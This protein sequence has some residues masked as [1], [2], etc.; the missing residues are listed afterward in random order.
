M[1]RATEPPKVGQLPEYLSREMRRLESELQDG[2]WVYPTLAGSF[3]SYGGA[4]AQARFCRNH[5]GLVV[6]GGL[7]RDGATGTNSYAVVMTLPEKYRPS[8]QLV[9]ATTQGGATSG[10][11]M[12]LDVRTNGEVAA[13]LWNQTWLSLDGISFYAGR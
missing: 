4:Y 8:H 7:V 9:F 1:F 12:R 3:Q 2:G 13:Y 11:F 6:L 5:H 10:Q